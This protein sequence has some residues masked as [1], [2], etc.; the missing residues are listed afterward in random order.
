MKI[1][2]TSRTLANKFL[3]LNYVNIGGIRIEK[4]H[5]E[6]E[7]DPS[8]DQCYNCGALNPGHS[9]EMCPNRTCCLRCGYEGHAFFECQYIPN[10]PST[11]YNEQKTNIEYNA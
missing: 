11:E 7:V 2:F 3:E 1:E 6:P 8:I 4:H 5:M 10:I 9:R